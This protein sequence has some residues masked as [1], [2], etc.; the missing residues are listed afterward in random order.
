MQGPIIKGQLTSTRLSPLVSGNMLHNQQCW[1]VIKLFSA[2]IIVL[3]VCCLW[4]KYL[5]GFVS[6]YKVG[7]DDGSEI[8]VVG[9]SIL[10]IPWAVLLTVL[11]PLQLYCLFREVKQ[12]LLWYQTWFCR[13]FA[14]FLSVTLCLYGSLSFD[15][16]YYMAYEVKGS[17]VNG[18]VL[19]LRISLDLLTNILGM[20]IMIMYIMFLFRPIISSRWSY[21]RKES[22][23][24]PDT[25]TGQSG[26]LATTLP[27]SRHKV[28]ILHALISAGIVLFVYFGG[29]IAVCALSFKKLNCYIYKELFECGPH[30]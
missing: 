21:F 4:L 27:K 16:V 23:A 17:E 28:D 11:L 30:L 24:A 3:H 15:I 14:L 29:F 22:V 7:T 26:F 10:L 20:L 1:H 12:D 9:C 5:H 25:T 2:F 19:P 6:P 13:I 8:L 18:K